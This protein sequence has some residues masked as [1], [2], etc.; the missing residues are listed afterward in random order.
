MA[1]K[2]MTSPLQNQISELFLII[3]KPIFEFTVF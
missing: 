1:L 3:P 2:K